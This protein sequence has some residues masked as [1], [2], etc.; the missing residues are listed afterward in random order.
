MILTNGLGLGGP[1]VTQGL[2]FGFLPAA[3]D[4]QQNVYGG[5]KGKFYDD[6]EH[7]RKA[8][9]LLELKRSK[10][11]KAHGDQLDLELPAQEDEVE[12]EEPERFAITKGL[13]HRGPLPRIV[14][15]RVKRIITS[16]RTELSGAAERQ[17]SINKEDEELK[18]LLMAVMIADDDE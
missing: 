5:G 15:V 12:L 11:I 2:G 10:W 1:L 9:E 4:E 14:P 6:E 8:W 7:V 16:G 13:R 18:A 3:V 17:F